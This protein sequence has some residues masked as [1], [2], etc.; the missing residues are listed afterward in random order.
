MYG[1]E[2]VVSGFGAAMTRARDSLRRQGF[3]GDL[4]EIGDTGDGGIAVGLGR[5]V[6]LDS[7][8][9]AAGVVGRN[10]GQVERIGTSLHLVPLAGATEAVV[11]GFAL[12]GYRFDRY[13]ARR[14]TDH[15]VELH[16]ANASDVERALIGAEAEM[17]ARDLIN[18][19]A[20]DKAP[21]ALATLI[22]ARARS[23]GIETEVWDRDR[24]LAEQMAGTLA[25]AAGSDRPPRFVR[26]SYR[27]AGATF[28]LALVGKGI[29]FDSGGLSLKTADMMEPMKTDMSGAA[30]VAGAVWAIARRR[31]RINVEAYLPLTDN[32]PGGLAAKPG[33]VIRYR[34]RRTI[35]VLNTDAEGRLVL[36]DGLVLASES[37]ADLIVDIATLTGA[38]RIALGDRIGAVVGNERASTAGDIDLA[39]AAGAV[40]GERLWQMPLARDYRH[41][42][43]SNVADV[44]NTGG[45]YGG[46]ITA[47]LILEPFA[48]DRRWVH[49]DIAGPARAEKAHGWYTAGGTGFG[50]RTLVAL[51]EILAGRTRRTSRE[52]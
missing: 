31:L 46:V 26:L 35:E 21:E 33:D 34:N 14:Q 39:I 25:V 12:G 44:K 49:I 1:L 36:A 42:I 23:A 7:L 27:P 40:A 3:T 51:A 50:T 8:R 11:E 9:S 43:E 20:G 41:L 28:G 30:A 19:P 47:S 4:G 15:V 17:F 32:M 6:T 16:G 45:R 29:V 13:R 38:Q 52:R 37:D 24:M 48:G 10:L 18:T 22:A 2:P 5:E